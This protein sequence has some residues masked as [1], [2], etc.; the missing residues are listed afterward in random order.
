MVHKLWSIE[1]FGVLPDVKLPVSKDNARALKQLEEMVCFKDG[2]Y[3]APLFWP[4]D[5]PDMPNNHA[6]ALSRFQTLGRGPKKTLAKAKAYEATIED[7]LNQNHAGKLTAEELESLIGRTWYLP[8]HAVFNPSKP[9]K[10]RIVF[11]GAASFRGISLNKCLLTGP[12]LLTP[13]IGILLRL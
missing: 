10:C 2:R 6:V 7:Y 13:L 5:H 4:M 9:G 1:S 12:D 11:D 8:H 3:E